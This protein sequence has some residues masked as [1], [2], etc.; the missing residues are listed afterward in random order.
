MAVTSEQ[1]LAFIEKAVTVETML[2]A[3]GQVVMQTE[4]RIEGEA[5]ANALKHVADLACHESGIGFAQRQWD[6]QHGT[7]GTVLPFGPRAN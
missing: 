5:L 2:D 3:E 1:L 7:Q 6:D 4:P